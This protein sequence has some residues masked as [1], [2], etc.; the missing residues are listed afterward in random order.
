MI[1]DYLKGTEM[2]HTQGTMTV[3]FLSK[4][5]SALKKKQYRKKEPK[6]DEADDFTP[7][8]PLTDR[9]IK[10]WGDYSQGVRPVKLFNL[11]RPIGINYIDS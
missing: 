11:A 3:W 7:L 4:A 5:Y 10:Q 2:P 8:V 9:Q 1:S 6:H